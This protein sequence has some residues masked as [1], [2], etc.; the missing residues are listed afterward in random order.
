MKKKKHWTLFFLLMT[1]LMCTGGIYGMEKLEITSHFET[2][3]VDIALKEY[4]MQGDREVAWTDNPL[5]LPADEISK[6]PRIE[7]QGC[8]CYVRAKINIRN[9][10][11]IAEE[12]LIGVSKDWIV[13]DDG[14]FYY[15]KSLAPKETVDIFQG[16][17]IP[18]KGT[19]GLITYMRTDSTRISDVARAAAKEQI[20]NIY[21]KQ[22]YMDVRVDAIQ[23]KNFTP[24]FSTAAPWGNVKEISAAKAGSYEVRTYR[25]T[26]EDGFKIKYEADA[27]K[28]ISNSTDFFEKIPPMMPG[29]RY[30]DCV[31]ILNQSEQPL[32]LYF[33]SVASAENELNQKIRLKIE[34]NIHGVDQ[35]IYEGSLGEATLLQ[36]LLL[37]KMPEGAE[38]E[39]WFELQVPESL[40]NEYAL[41]NSQITWI[42]STKSVEE[43]KW[44]MIKTGD[45][46]EP[47][48]YAALLF[49]A[50]GLLI[51][52]GV[53]SRKERIWKDE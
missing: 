52:L 9:I 12:F 8:A 32:Y 53:K 47:G 44:E 46:S 20:E 27:K 14:Y 38:G 22:F 15:E 25:G 48:L 39:L 16:V 34:S 5:V 35:V 21:G 42:F 17:K 45:F 41:Q 11:G 24:Q 40:R 30:R 18:E 36:E 51:I 29:D 3:I 2:G 33:R 26:N 4:A 13:G 28:L 49:G 50:G 23:S 1:V 43:P 6:I 31:Q 19:V 7:N 37:G 10:D